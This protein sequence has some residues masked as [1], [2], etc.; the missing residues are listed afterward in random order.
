MT[1]L[2][3]ASAKHETE[4]RSR[5]RADEVIWALQICL[6]RAERATEALELENARSAERAAA[7]RYM[8]GRYRAFR[9]RRVSKLEEKSLGYG[10]TAVFTH[11]I[12]LKEKLDR[13]R[14][15][16]IEGIHPEKDFDQ[17]V[18]GVGFPG[19]NK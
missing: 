15:V 14:R 13:S 6:L 10:R 18:D 3:A 17:K 8:A 11:P 19:G 1:G 9:C 4:G 12:G 5:L 2:W 7:L 16:E